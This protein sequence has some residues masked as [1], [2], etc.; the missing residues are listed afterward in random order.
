VLSSGGY[1][2]D[3][4]NK[5]FAISLEAFKFGQHWYDYTLNIDKTILEKEKGFEKK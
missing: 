3:I 5:L 2:M 4:G 1:L